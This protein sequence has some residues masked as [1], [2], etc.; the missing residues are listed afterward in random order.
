MLEVDFLQ[1]DDST[2][3]SV[4][5]EGPSICLSSGNNC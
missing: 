4:G 5:K 1:L 2:G 3:S